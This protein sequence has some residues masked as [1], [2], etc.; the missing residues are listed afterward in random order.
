MIVLLSLLDRQNSLNYAAV[1]D[2]ILGGGHYERIGTCS[3]FRD[4]KGQHFGELALDRQVSG[5][6]YFFYR[7]KVNNEGVFWFDGLDLMENEVT[8]KPTTQLK[9]MIVG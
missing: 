5:D 6:L 9:E 2:V 8:D 3:A 4:E 7:S 1:T